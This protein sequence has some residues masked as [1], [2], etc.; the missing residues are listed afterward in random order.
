MKQSWLRKF[1]LGFYLSANSAEAVRGN[2]PSAVLIAAETLLFPSLFFSPSCFSPQK[3]N[4]CFS[5]W[6]HNLSSKGGQHCSRLSEASAPEVSHVSFCTHACLWLHYFITSANFVSLY[7]QIPRHRTIQLPAHDQNAS[8]SAFI[9]KPVLTIEI[10]RS[11]LLLFAAGCFL[12]WLSSQW[13][14]QTT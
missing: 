1:V 4:C 12:Q 7:H 9:V 3:E 11:I 10:T 8:F 13:T 2:L 5:N 6:V 14:L